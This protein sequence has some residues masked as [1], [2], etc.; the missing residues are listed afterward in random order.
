MKD[1]RYK[2]C[3]NCGTTELAHRNK[4][5]CPIMSAHG[6]RRWSNTKKFEWSGNYYE[7]K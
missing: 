3:K 7:V 2:V 1:D 6:G 4:T 5:D